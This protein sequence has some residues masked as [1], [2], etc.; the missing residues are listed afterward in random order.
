MIK[1]NGYRISPTEIEDAALASGAAGA[2][3]AFGVT[4]D[5]AGQRIM[6]VATPLGEAPDARLRA[7]L[8]QALPSY[9]QP[10]IEW[11]DT[12]PRLANG[13]LDRAAVKSR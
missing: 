2:A 5:R 7:A 1:A 10:A 6:L 8:L 12:L 13:K 4:D 11:R 3:V 9:M